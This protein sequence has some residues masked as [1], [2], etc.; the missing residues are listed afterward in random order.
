MN[1]IEKITSRITADTQAEIDRTMSEAKAEADKIAAKY[2]GL[3]EKESADAQ[4][5]NEKAAAERE[6]RLVSVAQMEARKEILA[7]KQRQVEVVFGKALET[8][9]AMPED[10]YIS[11]AA[12]LLAQAAPNGKGEAV[13]APAD[14]DRVGK[15]AVE[16]ANK[17]LGG[18]LALSSETRP[19]KGGFILVDG[20]VEI[21]CTFDTLVRLQKGEMAGEVAK[22][23]FPDA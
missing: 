17:K 5:K 7:T 19:L 11:V 9:C 12:D 3:A 2:R 14:R 16:A 22:I 20:S 13:F 15:A 23:L 6:E 10:Q 21:N 8:L 18:K 4:A 1:G